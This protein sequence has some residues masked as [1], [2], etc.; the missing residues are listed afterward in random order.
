MLRQLEEEL[1]CT[2]LLREGRK[3]HLTDSGQAVYQRGLAIFRSFISW[4]RKSVTST[5]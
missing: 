2:L 5:S 3:L 1:G 4:R